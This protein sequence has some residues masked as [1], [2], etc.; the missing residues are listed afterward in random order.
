[1]DLA[2]YIFQNISHPTYGSTRWSCHCPHR[3]VISNY[4]PLESRLDLAS[5]LIDHDGCN[6]LKLPRLVLPG[7]H[8]MPRDTFL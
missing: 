8:E 4:P 5:C 3:K 1:M 2:E 6:I 7:P